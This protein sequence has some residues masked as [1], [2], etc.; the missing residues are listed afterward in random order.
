MHNLAYS[1]NVAKYLLERFISQFC[2]SG[3][4][5]NNTK[6]KQ[7]NGVFQSECILYTFA[8]KKAHAYV[9][10]LE[11]EIGAYTF[12]HSQHFYKPK[13]KHLYACCRNV[14]CYLRCSCCCLRCIHVHVQISYYLLQAFQYAYHAY[15]PL[16]NSHTLHQSLPLFFVSYRNV[17]NSLRESNVENFSAVTLVHQFACIAVIFHSRILW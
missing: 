16:A 7:V 3:K 2:Y 9:Y 8:L 1:A 13:A 11:I 12:A 5:I 6:G 4:D 15:V 17:E 14:S 10:I